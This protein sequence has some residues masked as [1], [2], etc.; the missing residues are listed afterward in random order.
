MKEIRYSRDTLNRQVA[1]FPEGTRAK[2]QKLLTFK[3]GTKIIAE[4]LNLKVQP[5][6]ITGS[7]MLFD[8]GRKTAYSSTVVYNFLPTIDM[9]NA[10]EDWYDN[11]AIQMQEIIDDELSYNHRS[12]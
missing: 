5:I 9:T 10:P 4:K 12:R 1:I 11:V 8:E 2:S 6:V 7:K 3:A